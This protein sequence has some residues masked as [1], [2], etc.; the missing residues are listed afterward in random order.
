MEKRKVCHH[1]P[2]RLDSKKIIGFEITLE[3]ETGNLIHK[4]FDTLEELA[5]FAKEYASSPTNI[6]DAISP[7]PNKSKLANK[8]NSMILKN[9]REW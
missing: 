9:D 3:I 8:W 7:K 5:E 4:K 6:L 1:K 2:L